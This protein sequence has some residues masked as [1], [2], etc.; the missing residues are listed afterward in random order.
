[1]ENKPIISFNIR[2]NK[3]A[4]G[5][6]LK[7]SLAVDPSRDLPDEDGGEALGPQPLVHAQKVDLHHLHG[8]ENLF[9]LDAG[10]D[11]AVTGNIKSYDI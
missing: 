9:K 1:M 2:A 10:C 7:E 8:P 3:V 6:C 4:L 11:V 5:S